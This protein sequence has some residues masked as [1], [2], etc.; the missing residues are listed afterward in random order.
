[1]LPKRKD[2]NGEEY[3]QTFEELEKKYPHIGPNHI[4]DI[5]S[6]IGPILDRE[7]V[8]SVPGILSLLGA[9]RQS[10]LRT[11]DTVSRPKQLKEYCTRLH[12]M[13]LSDVINRKNAH[14][15]VQVLYG[16]QAAGPIT[17]RLVVTPCF[18]SKLDLIRT[19]LG[20]LTAVYCV[21]FDRSGKYIITGADDLLVKLWSAIDGRLLATFRGASAEITDIAVNLDNTLLAAGS[22]D[23][24]L[25]VWDMQTCAPVAV[26][27]AHTGMITSVNFCPSP[28]REL[29]YLV[30]TS[31]DGSI[32]FWQYT[33]AS[34]RKTV[35]ASK[36]IQYLEKLRPGQAKMICASFSPGGL[37]LAAGSADNHVRVYMMSD[38][39][40]KRILEIESHTE[41]VDSIQWAHQGLRFVSGSKD[42][43]AQVWHF[44]TQQ[45]KNTKLNMCDRLPGIAPQEDDAKK[46]KVTMVSWDLTDDWIVTAVSDHTVSNRNKI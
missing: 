35:F 12:G 44:E 45:W 5:C 37:F 41:T 11:N 15:V 46:A 20:H 13:P 42:G 14:N 9:G 36:P 33:T 18:Y 22:L 28:S 3:E 38:E 19:T 31:T 25:R 32:A 26:L 27:T 2:W 17:R 7:L 21:L 30:T 1:M 16:R 6:R 34:N 10:L 40:P 29:K 39:G 23:R 43:T 24:I 4:L 8:P